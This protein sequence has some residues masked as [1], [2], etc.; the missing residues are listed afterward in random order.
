MASDPLRWQNR[1]AF[2]IGIT[3]TAG[4]LDALA[5]LFL[6]KVFLSFMTGNLLFLGLAAG[7]GQG[8]LLG[9]AA[10][11]LAAFLAGSAIG[12][13]LTGSRLA[14]DTPNATLRRTLG[15]EAVLLAVF[16]ALWVALGTPEDH[17]GPLHVLIA[18]GAG[19]MGFQAAVSLALRLPNI[20]TV[21]MTGTLAQL[22][23]LLGWWRR[24]GRGILE[25]TP[26]ASLMLA[27][28]LTYLIA[29][30]IVA[31]GPE[32]GVMAFGPVVL[33]LATLAADS[34][35]AEKLGGGAVLEAGR[36]DELA[37]RS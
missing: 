14:A 12:A 29:A 27:L 37:A 35:I 26:S 11:A 10:V 6:G 20:A 30:L 18:V 31:F 8:G 32:S 16:G 7:T 17:P 5:F 36:H 3:A 33:L 15:I 21:A 22:G 4:W 9:R 28:C 1:P 2:L 34:R 23:A 25:T 19:A 13:R 24:E